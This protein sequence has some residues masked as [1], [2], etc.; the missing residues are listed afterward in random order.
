MN[1]RLGTELSASARQVISEARGADDPTAEDEA[2]VKARWLAGIAAGAGVSSLSEAVRAAAT[3][4]GLKAGALAAA[5][6]AATV[7]VYLGWPQLSESS[8]GAA[9]ADSPTSTTSSPATSSPATSSPATSSPATSSPAPSNAAPSNA[10]PSNAA[11]GPATGPSVTPPV[12]GIPTPAPAVDRSDVPP[13]VAPSEGSP[14]QEQP[15]AEPPSAVVSPSAL[16]P[17]ALPPSALPVKARAVKAARTATPSRSLRRALL[18]KAHAPTASVAPPALSG[19]LGEEIALLSEIRNNLQSGSAARALEQLAAYRQRF[20]RPGLAM[21]ADAL[22]VDA[23]C[24][25]GQRDAARA[26]ANAFISRWPGS[27]LQQRVS[28]ACP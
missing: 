21:E 12:A 18:E 14:A 8:R 15:A 22:Q 13:S 16:P 7:G 9:P 19:Q 26:A 27:P 17:S 1:E 20:G 5:L 2:R 28:A 6:A 25:A 24:R 4:W 23:L 11:P 3:G 10:A